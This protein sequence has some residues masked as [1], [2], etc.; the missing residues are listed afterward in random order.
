VNDPVAALKKLMAEREKQ[1]HAMLGQVVEEFAQRFHDAHG[2]TLQFTPP[3]VERIVAV[4]LEQGKPVRDFCAD[5]FKD[6][7]FGLKLIAQNTGRKEFKIDTEAVDNPD[8]A[9]SDLVV[10]SYRPQAS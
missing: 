5:K 2:L 6:Y 3:A 8:K 1:E 9:L 4:A 10:E 7:Q